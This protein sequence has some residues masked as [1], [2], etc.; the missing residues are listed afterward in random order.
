MYWRQ[1]LKQQMVWQTIASILHTS[2]QLVGLMIFQKK[3][4]VNPSSHSAL[5]ISTNHTQ[6]TDILYAQCNS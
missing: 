3:D 2:T 6:D 5:C 4:D 1:I